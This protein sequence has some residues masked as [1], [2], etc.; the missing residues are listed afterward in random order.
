MENYYFTTKKLTVGYHGKPLISD[1]EIRL[2][3]GEILALIGPNGSGKSTILKSIAGQL[4]KIGGT[5]FFGGRKMEEIGRKELAKEMSVVLTQRLNTELMSCRD[6]T[7]AGRYPYTGRL[8]FLSENDRRRVDEALEM[9][10][11]LD[12]A[13][14]DY[15]NV[16]DGQQQRVL[17]AR[18]ICQE[19]EIIIL[20]EPTSYLDI[21]HKLIML[22]ILQRLAK[23]RGVTVILSLHELEMA[24]KI[25]DKVLC[26][27]GR[28][29]D[30]YGTPEEIFHSEYIERLYDLD[31]GY[32]NEVFGSV[33]MKRW[34]EVLMDERSRCGTHQGETGEEMSRYGMC[35]DEMEEERHR[36]GTCQNKMEEERHSC[37]TCQ[38]ETEEEQH[39][40]EAYRN[41]TV[42]EQPEVFVIAGS[43]SG[44]SVFRK[45]HRQGIAFAAGVLHKND[46]DYEL[47]KVLACR[48][49]EERAYER[50]G[51]PS[52]EEAAGVMRTCGRVICCLKDGDFGEMNER[53]RDLLKI[54]EESGIEVI[55]EVRK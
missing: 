47:A 37:R 6:V 53:N 48:V 31:N 33:E 51:A 52:F 14:D 38:D 39:R 23:Q 10:G 19:P 49:I 54:A 55:R 12:C 32:Y 45:L 44:A 28:F 36:C 22:Q 2:R 42:T 40:C 26:V 8:G 1:I 24:Q 27:K 18:A 5:V 7:A 4:P 50:I 13:D 20:D 34:D 21:R 9:V 25:S 43:G 11:M 3:R 15:M 16:S 29:V 46:I 17:L 30:R 41:E 35:Q